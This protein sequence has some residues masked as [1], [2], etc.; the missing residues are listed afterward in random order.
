M[1]KEK[2]YSFGGDT[3]REKNQAKIKKQWDDSGV[4]LIKK[5]LGEDI[6]K[7]IPVGPCSYASFL[8]QN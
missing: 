4:G 2:E 5:G 8:T 1:K 3:Q 7:M 6:I